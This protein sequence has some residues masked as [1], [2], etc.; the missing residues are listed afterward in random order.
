ML[1]CSVLDAKQ[2]FRFRPRSFF[3]PIGNFCL[4]QRLWNVKFIG[5][6]WEGDRVSAIA[7]LKFCCS[8]FDV[9]AMK[10][11]FWRQRSLEKCR[12]W[13]VL[14]FVSLCG[15]KDLKRRFFRRW[16]VL[17]DFGFNLD[18]GMFLSRKDFLLRKWSFFD[19][20]SE[21]GSVRLVGSA[22]VAVGVQKGCAAPYAEADA[23]A[24][25]V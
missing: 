9:F 13:F 10:P 22:G 14:M 5:W 20:Y 18:F 25:G 24:L 3:V 6:Q 4:V 8:V 1:F 19:C 15:S 7:I 2:N 11:K 16:E 23:V 12:A 17:L 21:K